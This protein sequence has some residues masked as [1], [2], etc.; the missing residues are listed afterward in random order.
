MIWSN[1]LVFRDSDK[2]IKV[3]AISNLSQFR[4]KNKKARILFLKFCKQISWQL[5]PHLCL[6]LLSVHLFL[7]GMF[8]YVLKYANEHDDG[9]SSRRMQDVDRV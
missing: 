3:T 8:C 4:S 5:F 9:I 6:N 2:I 1:P 7:S